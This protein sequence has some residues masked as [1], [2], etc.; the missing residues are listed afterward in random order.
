MSSA[1]LESKLLFAS[2]WRA[3]LTGRLILLRGLSRGFVV[4][5]LAQLGGLLPRFI[6]IVVGII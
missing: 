6:G 3:G 5:L 1:I 2:Y 4:K